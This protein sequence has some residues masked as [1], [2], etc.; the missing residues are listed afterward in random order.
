MRWWS[1]GGNVVGGDGT[2][3][4]VLVVITLGMSSSTINHVE[5]RS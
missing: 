2:V 3:Y 5:H 4:C 1:C